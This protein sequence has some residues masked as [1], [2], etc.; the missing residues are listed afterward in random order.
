M[1]ALKASPLLTVA[2]LVNAPICIG[3]EIFGAEVPFP[4]APE[5][6]CPHAH[7]VPS[8]LMAWHAR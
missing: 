6:A 8:A 5:V 1:D 3:D 4:N 7:N 2:Q